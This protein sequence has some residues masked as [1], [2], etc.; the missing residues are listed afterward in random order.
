MSKLQLLFWACMSYSDF[1]VFFDN[2]F[3]VVEAE[4]YRE[5]TMNSELIL[6]STFGPSTYYRVAECLW[7]SVS[8]IKIKRNN[9]TWYAGLLWELSKTMYIKRLSN[10]RIMLFFSAYP[11]GLP[12]S[13]RLLDPNFLPDSKNINADSSFRTW[14][15]MDIY[16][17][18]GL[19][20]RWY[21]Y[22]K[23]T[24]L[25]PDLWLELIKKKRVVSASSRNI[26]QK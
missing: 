4:W 26:T 21:L 9:N 13:L 19:V 3:S 18:L 22:I 1:K 12:I 6:N 16:A 7:V 15:N 14:G 17:I 24:L 11:T 25:K 5:K 2:W 8:P 23:K 20:I 10:M